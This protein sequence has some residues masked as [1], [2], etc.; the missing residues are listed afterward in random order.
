MS[1]ETQLI[2]TPAVGHHGGAMPEPD[3]VDARRLTWIAGAT[4]VFLASALAVLGAIYSH[5]GQIKAPPPPQPFPQPRVTADETV[6]LKHILDKQRQEL[7]GYHW[8]DQGH[9]LI[10]IP[11][12]RAMQLIAQKGAHAYDPVAAIA[13]ALASP[14]AGAERATTPSAAPA[15]NVPN[16]PAEKSP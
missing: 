11:I 12:E 13:G 9:T 4:L 10:Q 15:G 3:N 5:Q 16:P 7:S 14:Q 2:E 1:V 6:E 8:A